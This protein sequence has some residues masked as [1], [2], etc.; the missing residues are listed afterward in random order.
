MTVTERLGVGLVGCGAAGQSIHAAALASLPELFEVRQCMDPDRQVADEVARRLGGLGTTD[1]DVLLADDS[2]DVVV[3]A[4]PGWAHADQVVAACESGKR[5]VLCEK[6]VAES[7]ADTVRIAEASER[8]GVPVVVGTMQRHD[9]ALRR[10]EEAWGDLP[11]RAH[12]V[13]SHAF[14][15]PNAWLV[16]AVTEP[17]AAAPP[18]PGGGGGGGGGPTKPF[19][20]LMF[21]GLMWGLAVHHL[22]LIRLAVPDLDDLEVVTAVPTASSGYA[23]TLR[24][25]D[26]VVQLVSMLNQH[27]RTEWTF[28]L[29]AADG[30][31]RIDYPAGYVPTRSA[32]ATLSGSNGVVDE[33]RISATHETGYRAQYRHLAAVARGEVAPLTPVADSV[34]DA[35]LMERLIAEADAQWAGRA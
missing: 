6:P 8:T 10:L 26:R 13:R 16:D 33:R 19:E 34:A 35:R 4:S 29:I 24:S 5:A 11:S 17:L 2:V 18:T 25:G 31:A 28:E 20:L 23:A 32:T 30:R 15:G 22:P 12:L 14:V 3:I 9:P 21:A 1:L 27:A 7:L